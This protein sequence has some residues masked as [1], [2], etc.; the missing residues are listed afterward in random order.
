MPTL[1]LLFGL[2]VISACGGSGDI[3]DR[4]STTENPGSGRYLPQIV[5]SDL[6]IGEN[7]FVVGVVDQEE[8]YP[9]PDAQILAG[10]ERAS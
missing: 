10:L 4:R 2:L 8:N 3:A 6:A 9:V 7:R 1:G 5:S